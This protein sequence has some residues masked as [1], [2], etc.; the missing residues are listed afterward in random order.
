MEQVSD[1]RTSGNGR[2]ANLGRRR[3]SQAEDGVL[4]WN[5]RLAYGTGHI[6][7]DLC[8]SMWFTYLLLFFHKVLLFD[9]LYSGVIL[10]SGQIA[11]GLSTVFVGY[12]SDQGDD[13]RLCIRSVKF[14]LWFGITWKIYIFSSTVSG[15]ENA[16]AGT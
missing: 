16:R 13:M 11:D 4:S 10:A 15:T 6:L 14:R 7:N 9:N 8:A 1:T 3:S 2:Q 5:T 12:F